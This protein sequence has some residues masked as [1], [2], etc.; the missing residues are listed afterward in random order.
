MNKGKVRSIDHVHEGDD[1][2]IVTWYASQLCH[3]IGPLAR[4][5][6][7]THGI[8]TVVVCMD[9]GD[10]IRPDEFG[11]HGPAI[12]DIVEIKEHLQP[13]PHEE[14]DV[15]AFSETA[16]AFESR[17]GVSLREVVRSDRH[18]G[19]GYVT[20]AVFP[21]SRHAVG[22]TDLQTMD[23]ALRLCGVHERLLQR[24]RPLLVLSYPGMVASMALA[25]VGTAM[26]IPLRGLAKGRKEREQ[27][28]WAINKYAEWWGLREAVA[29]RLAAN[30]YP[31]DSDES[32]ELDMA[33][34]FRM[35]VALDT[36]RSDAS[37]RGLLRKLDGLARRA[38]LDRLR[39]REGYGGYLFGDNLA[40]VVRMWRWRR[41]VVREVLASMDWLENDTPFIFFPLQTEPESNLMA[42]APMC[43]NQLTII[44]WLCKAAPAG[45]SVAVKEHPGALA[46]RP[47][48]F[49]T[50][51]RR[52]PNLIVVPTLAN[53]EA[54][55]ARAR[56][57]AVING[58][59]GLQAATAGRPV[60]TFHPHY[61]GLALPHLLYAGSYA[62]TAQALC[63][64]RDG[65]IASDSELRRAGRAYR[66]AL[67]D[68][69]FTLSDDALI[70][71]RPGKAPVSTTDVR[72]VAETLLFSL[73]PANR[74]G[75][76]MDPALADTRS[77]AGIG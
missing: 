15:R 73:R 63:K 5:L 29:S 8:R 64:L 49:W 69:A 71:G 60:L 74:F 70:R 61:Q 59:L 48:G 38:I 10:L 16:G 76:V 56:V 43:D 25:E 37:L 27:F 9:R 68:C 21:R 17:L 32:S 58:T 13:R 7:E 57:V 47:A 66:D 4:E 50:R 34:P 18:F 44:D 2:H 31:M 28:H 51:L 65:Q 26:G 55:A 19:I 67:D 14:I 53:G 22:L 45:W 41:S 3:L 6:H 72:M 12:A 62:E 35:Q 30:D 36:L 23:I 46:P 54:V 77:E 39:R 24:W 75:G 33:A 11:L 42:E 1:R 40:Y 52:Y 20:G